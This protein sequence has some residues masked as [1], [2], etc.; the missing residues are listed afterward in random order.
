MGNISKVSLAG[1]AD[2]HAD[3]A[4]VGVTD[5]RPGVRGAEKAPSLYMLP[6]LN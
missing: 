3:D 4:T 2:E 5:D 1:T 6:N